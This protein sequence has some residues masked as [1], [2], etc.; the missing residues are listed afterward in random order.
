MS[1]KSTNFWRVEKK[2]FCRW[3]SSDGKIFVDYQNFSVFL[4]FEGYFDRT[5]VSSNGTE[6]LNSLF[7]LSNWIFCCCETKNMF[8]YYSKKI[9]CF[10]SIRVIR[11]RTDGIWLILLAF[12][13]FPLSLF[14]S[15]LFTAFQPELSTG[16]QEGFCSAE[17]FLQSTSVYVIELLIF[18]VCE[19]FQADDFWRWKIVLE[20]FEKGFL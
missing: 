19:A 16:R 18:Y 8:L 12:L 1:K 9:W 11:P 17:S 15:P 14:R 7:E 20:T 4:H 5:Q 10:C 6:S 3:N 2:S 13:D